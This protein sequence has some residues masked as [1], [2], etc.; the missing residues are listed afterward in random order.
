MQKV[1]GY[2]RDFLLVEYKE[3][4]MVLPWLLGTMRIFG[5]KADKWDCNDSCFHRDTKVPVKT[6]YKSRSEVALG[7]VVET[8]DGKGVVNDIRREINSVEVWIEGRSI[9]MFGQA[10][11]F[12]SLW[13]IDPSTLKDPLE[14]ARDHGF[15]Q[16]C[17]GKTLRPRDCPDCASAKLLGVWRGRLLVQREDRLWLNPDPLSDLDRYGCMKSSEPIHYKSRDEIPLGQTVHRLFN[18]K[19]LTGIVVDTQM[20][21]TPG[22]DEVRVWWDNVDFV[23]YNPNGDLVVHASDLWKGRD[24]ELNSPIQRLDGNKKSPS[25]SI[26]GKRVHGQKDYRGDVCRIVAIWKDKALMQDEDDPTEWHEGADFTMDYAFG[27]K[28]WDDPKD[29]CYSD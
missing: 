22:A 18:G 16:N 1:L 6:R 29:P 8:P 21:T 2:W 3:G 25:N 14:T 23:G 15:H 24:D 11:P 12:E 28:H 27:C 26:L 9:G 13:K 7:D 17:L 19:V 4:E 5:C 20:Y 10:F